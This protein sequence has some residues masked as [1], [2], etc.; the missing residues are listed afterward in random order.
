[1][2][3]DARI[4]ASDFSGGRN[5]YDPEHLVADNQSPD[6]QNIN[7]LDRGFEKRRGNTAFNSSAMVDA[8][9]AVVGASYAKLGST[10][11]L[12]AVAGTAVFKSDGLDGTM[13]TVTGTLTVTSGQNYLWTILPYNDLLIGFGGGPD[14]P[15]KYSGSGNAAA[16]GGSPPSAKGAFAANNRI[17]AIGSTANPSRIQWNILGDPE[18]WTG[19]GSGSQDVAKN[20]GEELLA[21][22]LIG[23]DLA[24]LF[25]NSST[26][27]MPLT[28]APFGVYQLQRGI[29]AAGRRSIVNVNGEIFFIT[30]SLRMKSTSDGRTFVDY[31]NAVNDLWNS[32]NTTRIPY[33]EGIYYPNLQQIVWMVS[34]GSSSTNNAA[35]IWDVRSKAWLYHPSGF[36]GNVACLVQNRRLFTGHYN[37]KLFEQ[38]KASTYTDASE[39]SPYAID[40]Y[41]ASRW[42]RGASLS[43]ILHPRWVDVSLVSQTAGTLTVSAGF[44]FSPDQISESVSMVAG[45]YVYDDASSV[46]DTA[47]YSGA[48]SLMRRKFMVGRGNVFQVKFRN[49]SASQGFTLQGYTVQLRNVDTQKL[50]SVR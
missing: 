26:H 8:T 22:T 47:R 23:P 15:W 45:G 38:D 12:M 30:P 48:T 39:A 27:L 41:W 16:L 9:T 24:L 2:N 7:L 18:D 29:G 32:V 19:T 44:D 21:G 33:I 49:N 14:A 42:H 25:K 43:D 4:E 1:M 17:F 35:I 28:S 10:E 6:C 37:G 13:D 5:S 20:D 50:F 31:P 36:K 46:Y 3:R 34:T 40:A 11:Y